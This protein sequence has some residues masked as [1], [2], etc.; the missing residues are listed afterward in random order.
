MNFGYKISFLALDKGFIENFGPTGFSKIGL[1]G[2]NNF[3]YY[4][5]NIIY[6]TTF[7]LMVG[8]LFFFTCFFIKNFGIF[9]NL[10]LN[11]LF[12]SYCI[13]FLLLI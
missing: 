2:A 7:Y 12:F 1:S 10:N 13:F 6:Q 11:F 9:I 8:V 3:T 4:S 5:R